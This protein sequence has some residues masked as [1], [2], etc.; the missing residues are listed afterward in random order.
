MDSQVVRQTSSY[1]QGLVLGLTM[2]EVVLLLVFCLLL[3]MSTF[4]RKEQVAREAAESLLRKEQEQGRADR[5]F[6]RA[7][8]RNPDLYE[9]LTKATSTGNPNAI[10]EFWRELVESHAVISSVREG[11]A[12]PKDIRELVE[13]SRKLREGGVSPDQAIR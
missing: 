10:D 3:G 2:A 4:A 9:R 13:Q 11:G 1:R 12:L 5:D 7:I 6:V 8:K